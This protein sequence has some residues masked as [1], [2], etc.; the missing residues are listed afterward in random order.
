[1]AQD[2][3]RVKQGPQPALAIP[4]MMLQNK[5]SICLRPCEGGPC[6]HHTHLAK[7]SAHCAS[8]AR[9]AG[10]PNHDSAVL[11]VL[12]QLTCARCA[13]TEHATQWASGLT[14][15]WMCPSLRVPFWVFLTETT[16]RKSSFCRIPGFTTHLFNHD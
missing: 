8:T 1:M 11:E 14:N 5:L 16:N 12:P 7:E 2:N 4:Q 3:T 13:S 9:E 10:P 15:T 6:K